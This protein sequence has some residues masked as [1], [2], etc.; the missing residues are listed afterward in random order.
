MMGMEYIQI[1]I[2]LYNSY[3]FQIGINLHARGQPILSLTLQEK[4]LSIQIIT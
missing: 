4:N 2:I 3:L 1:H